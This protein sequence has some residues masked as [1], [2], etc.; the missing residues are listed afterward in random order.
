MKK[1]SKNCLVVILK[2]WP[3]LVK[4]YYIFL[5]FGVHF[6]NPTCREN[7][8]TDILQV[9]VSRCICFFSMIIYISKFN[10]YYFWIVVYLM[11]TRSL[12]YSRTL[13][14]N[15]TENQNFKLQHFWH[16]LL[17]LFNVI[18]PGVWILYLYYFTKSEKQC[19][20]Q[21]NR[22]IVPYFTKNIFINNGF[23]DIVSDIYFKK[24]NYIIAQ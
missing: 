2:H 3:C 10:V 15:F 19:H 24:R 13:D 21:Q 22:L 23:K 9:F 17:T 5:C 20:H 12:V 7:E 6:R 8:T 16:F 1:C 4:I 18:R 11:I 14:S